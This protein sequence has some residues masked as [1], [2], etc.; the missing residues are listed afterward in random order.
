MMS[1]VQELIDEHKD[2][3]PT[4]LAKK[5][6]DACKA[7]ADARPK[8]Y[9]ATVTN[10]TAI[11]VMDDDYPEPR[12]IERTQTLILEL[13][14]AE[15]LRGMCRAGLLDKGIL[16]QEMLSECMSTGTTVLNRG[17]TMQILHSIEPYTPKRARKE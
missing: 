1:G 6:L 9:R 3:M 15:Q 10:V 8:L 11:V 17:T 2:E 12:L 7:E 13:V 4:A 16:D 14:D 5:L